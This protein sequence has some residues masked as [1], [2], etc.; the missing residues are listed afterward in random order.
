[1]I[2]LDVAIQIFQGCH[3][4]FS[5]FRKYT[6]VFDS[7]T[8]I[9]ERTCSAVG[10]VSLS[11]SFSSFIFI[12]VIMSA[13]PKARAHVNIRMF[14]T[15]M[16]QIEENLWNSALRCRK[17]RVMESKTLKG[18]NSPFKLREHSSYGGSSCRG[19]FIRVY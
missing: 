8:M 5:K 7:R 17:I 10:L 15:V 12:S 19:L 14:K 13:G 3:H 6:K 11:S 18:Q 1:M 9:A 2:F 16:T 4:F